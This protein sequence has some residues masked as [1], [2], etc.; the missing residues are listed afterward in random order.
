MCPRVP[1]APLPPR[2]ALAPANQDDGGLQD[3]DWTGFLVPPV[4]LPR[5][6][7]TSSIRAGGLV[8]TQQLCE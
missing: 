7:A 6:Q 4:C 8:T 2:Y 1:W 5:L 3:T